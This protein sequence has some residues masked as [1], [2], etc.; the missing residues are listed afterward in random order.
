MDYIRY[1]TRG[2]RKHAR[3]EAIKALA[4]FGLMALEIVICLAIF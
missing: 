2:T 1:S 3:A 4:V